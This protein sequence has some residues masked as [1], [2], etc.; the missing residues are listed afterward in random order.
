[1]P[2]AM[3]ACRQASQYVNMLTQHLLEG[4]G[5]AGGRRG[6]SVTSEMG[7]VSGGTNR[8]G[9]ILEPTA[10]DLVGRCG[11]L[12]DLSA[13]G[14]QQAKLLCVSSFAGNL[15]IL[16]EAKVPEEREGK[17]GEH[18][19]LKVSPPKPPLLMMSRRLLERR[20]LNRYTASDFRGCRVHK[21]AL[22]FD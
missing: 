7:I 14:L 8:E 11:V 1:M 21:W 17:A 16:I 3:T 6:P 19:L 2:H 10:V 22:V 15:V 20:H 13:Q 12:A 5:K 18:K 4:Q 9:V